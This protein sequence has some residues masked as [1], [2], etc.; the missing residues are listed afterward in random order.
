MA[1]IG[2]GHADIQESPRFAGKGKVSATLSTEALE[3]IND[4]FA[5]V[6]QRDINGR[7]AIDMR[8]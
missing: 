3:Q 6:R 5:R 1:V 2:M 7:V 8:T 4:I